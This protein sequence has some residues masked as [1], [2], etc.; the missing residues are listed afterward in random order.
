MTITST[1]DQLA[2][3]ILRY[4]MLKTCLVCYEITEADKNMTFMEF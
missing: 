3:N 4:F 1:M 2:T